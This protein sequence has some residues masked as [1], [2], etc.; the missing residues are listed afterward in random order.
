MI[1]AERFARKTPR[2]VTC[3][4]TARYKIWFHEH[5]SA[6]LW[7]PPKPEPKKPKPGEPTGTLHRG[8][9]QMR[10]E[11]RYRGD[12]G[13][14]AQVLKNGELRSARLLPTRALAVQWA[15]QQRGWLLGMAGPS[16][17]PAANL[18]GEISQE[19][20]QVPRARLQRLEGSRR[21]LAIV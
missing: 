7:N 17:Q 5:R 11:L 19:D 8:A 15:E 2:C 18:R 13:V 3:P 10:A 1:T 6:L 4:V 20:P 9:D 16:R 14:E 12:D 21:L